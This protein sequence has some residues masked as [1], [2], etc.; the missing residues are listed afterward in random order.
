MLCPSR[1]HVRGLSL[2][3]DLDGSP[4]FIVSRRRAQL[5]AKVRL[6]ICLLSAAVSSP[7]AIHRCY[8]V[9]VIICGN[10]ESIWG[11]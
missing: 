9:L 2:C 7:G 3:W 6:A 8:Y 10:R 4:P 5:L 11:I 1:T